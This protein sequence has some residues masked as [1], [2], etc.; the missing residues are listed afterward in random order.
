VLA[1]AAFDTT[2]LSASFIDGYAG[3]DSGYNTDGNTYLIDLTLTAMPL[4]VPP[5]T[6]LT[7]VNAVLD[8]NTDSWLY[9]ISS[10]SGYLGFGYGS[11]WMASQAMWSI[12][13]GYCA[14]QSF[15][16]PNGLPYVAST[17]S[18]YIGAGDYSTIFTGDAG[19]SVTLQSVTTD[20]AYELSGAWFGLN[21]TGVYYSSLGYSLSPNQATIALNF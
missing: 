4:G 3:T 10:S 21:T 20:N 19:N 9:G 18:L 5:T 2:N 13:L 12:E 6:A 7:K 8:V 14:N 17:P 11:D 15:T 1:N 16:D